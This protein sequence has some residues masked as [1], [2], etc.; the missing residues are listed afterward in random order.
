[1]ILSSYYYITAVKNDFSLSKWYADIIDRD[2]NCVIVYQAHLK[3]KFIQIK[4]FNLLQ[5]NTGGQVKSEIRLTNPYNV[6]HQPNSLIIRGKNL[7]GS[8]TSSQRPIHLDLL[9]QESGAIEWNCIL[10]QADTT[11]SIG[12]TTLHGYGYAEHLHMTIK[13]WEFDISEL[14]WGRFH[15]ENYNLVWIEWRGPMKRKWLFVNQQQLSDFVLN[16]HEILFEGGH[17]QFNQKRTLR[18]G[19][20]LSTV[21]KKYQ[22]LKKWF[23]LKTLLTEETKWIS[24]ASLKID[25]TLSHGH[26]IFEK[27]IWLK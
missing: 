17:L 4:Y 10:P 21:F 1:M 22:W 7:F 6:L 24:S 20:L 16:D 25:D 18:S 3:W 19:S 2:G 14:Y 5:L 13:P 9:K 27:V 12:K 26:A 15:T 11:L 23:P 8:W